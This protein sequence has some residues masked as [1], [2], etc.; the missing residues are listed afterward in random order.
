GKNTVASA[1]VGSYVMMC[2][3][4]YYILM[5]AL[6]AFIRQ[7][8]M[9]RYVFDRMLGM[10]LLVSAPDFIVPFSTAFIA[11]IGTSGFTASTR[12]APSSR[13]T[14]ACSPLRS[15]PSI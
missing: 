8:I 15:V 9:L 4:E 12:S 5:M 10:S 13:A 7:Y 2:V 11:L 1:R 14:E 3:P 6:L